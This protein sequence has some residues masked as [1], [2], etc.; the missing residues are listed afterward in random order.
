MNSLQDEWSE[1]PR[2]TVALDTGLHQQVP[3][4]FLPPTAISYVISQW[5]R[6]DRL[7]QARYSLLPLCVFVVV[8][9]VRA[10]AADPQLPALQPSTTSVAHFVSE[11][12]SRAKALENSS[13]MRSSFQSFTAAY[14]IAPDSIRYSDF[15]I[16]RLVYEAARD[17]G[18]WNVHWTITNMPPN[19]DRI[20][21]QWKSVHAVSTTAPTASAECDE[22]SALY[23]FLVERAGVRTVGLFWP[24]PNHTVAVWVVRPAGAPDVRVVVPTSQIFLDVTDS[25][26]T[27]KFN[28]WHQK[29]IFEYTRHDAPDSFELPAPL[30]SFFL[31]QIDRY[32]GASDSTLQE[33]RYLREGVLLKHWTAEE[34]ARDA[35]RRKSD[36]GSGP[37]ED[38]AAFQNFADDMRKGS[39]AASH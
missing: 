24:Y 15:V 18:F 5:Q 14:K 27:K 35:V 25:F 34:A 39:V 33:I 1:R 12:Q 29:T 36:L 19:S 4:K 38:L 7:V 28:P 16:A 6:Y 22:L 26:G 13:G 2:T 31:T 21:S 32:A 30:Y 11:I 3:E 23:A 8:T 17:A 9:V 10:K 37:A 20:W